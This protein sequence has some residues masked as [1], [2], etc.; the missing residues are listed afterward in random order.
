MKVTE[1]INEARNPVLNY[2]EKKAKDIV[3]RVT[4]F[5]TGNESSAATRLA[6]RFVRLDQAMKQQIKLRDAANADAKKLFEELFDA[7]DE[8]LTRVI[9]TASVTMTLSKA[10]RGK[11]KPNV[12]TVDFEAAYRELAEMVLG[13]TEQKEKLNKKIEAILAKHTTSTPARDTPAKLTTDVKLDEGIMDTLKKMVNTVVESI[14]NWATGYDKKLDAFKK[15]Y[16][17]A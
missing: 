10:V 6:K 14:K 11:D 4:V 1:L 5:L 12:I 2:L 7:E 15:K 13:L 8:I 9:E 3:V 17:L 16:K